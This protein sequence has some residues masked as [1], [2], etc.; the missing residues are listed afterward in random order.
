[1][2]SRWITLVLCFI[3]AV[4][5][6]VRLVPR[7]GRR[8]ESHASAERQSAPANAFMGLRTLVLEG[9]RANFGLEPGTSATQPFAVVTDWG[10]A[11]GA[12][13]IVAVADGSASVYSSG[14]G[15]SIGGGKL[16]ESIREAAIK[17]VEAAAAMQPLM[18]AT[19][20]FPLAARG[21]VNFY[22]VTDAGVFTATASEEDLESNRSQY[23][24]LARAARNIVEEYR[25]VS[26]SK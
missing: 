3:V 19:K 16:H 18:H 2:K 8:T 15:G 6:I 5:L 1:M 22:V 25:S 10:D 17:T 4:V 24:A 11:Q 14:G 26:E 12:R 13:T 9:S 23:S 21:Q 7:G 20:Q